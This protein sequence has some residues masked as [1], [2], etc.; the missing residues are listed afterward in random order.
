MRITQGSEVNIPHRTVVQ[1][2][3]AAE[4][5]GQAPAAVNALAQGAEGARSSM[6]NVSEAL[7]IAHT[8]KTIINQALSISSQLQNIAQQAIATGGVDRTEVGR[9]VAEINTTM[10]QATGRPVFAVIPPALE[11]GNREPVRMEIPSARDELGAMGR[12]AG[13][14]DA[15]GTIGDGTL[16]EIRNS[17]TR[18]AA[19]LDDII[20]SVERSVPGAAAG[21]A[22]GGPAA[23][24]K[25]AVTLAG[26]ISANPAGAISAQGNIRQ[27][28]AAGLLS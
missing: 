7:T 23:A 22:I 6:R 17:L 25:T 11:G 16:G 12:L 1:G 14:I 5:N 2:K 3:G 19:A 8:A 26:M 10:S 20:A 4:R 21:P 27:E 28:N 9:T 24:E 15:G 13:T 18:K